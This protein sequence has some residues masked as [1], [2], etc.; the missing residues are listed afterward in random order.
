MASVT[1]ATAPDTR[2]PRPSLSAGLRAIHVS[3]AQR[4][5]RVFLVPSKSGGDRF[6]SDVTEGKRTLPDVER[7]V[8]FSVACAED[9]DA[10][11]WV[12]AIRAEIEARRADRVDETPLWEL[13]DRQDRA[14]AE[15]DMAQRRAMMR[16]DCPIT[17]ERLD[18]S[19]RALTYATRAVVRADAADRAR[20]RP[21]IESTP[22]SSLMQR[23][24]NTSDCLR[25]TARE[26]VGLNGNGDAA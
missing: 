2:S 11:A 10:F 26:R 21:R 20:R 18:E 22:L 19:G 13:H 5:R 9:V 3:V 25:A 7:I 16:P 8:A 6:L 14:E 24:G 15:F 1:I 23:K 12:D 17:R 4:F